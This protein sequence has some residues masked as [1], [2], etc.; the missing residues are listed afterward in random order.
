[1]RVTTRAAHDTDTC[2]SIVSMPIPAWKYRH[3]F[4]TDTGPSIAS[5]IPAQYRDTDTDT[6]TCVQSYIHLCETVFYTH[7][8]AYARNTSVVMIVFGHF[9]VLNYINLSG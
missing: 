6:D 3:D 2:R 1:M 8:H 4:D 7:T 5:P 9:V